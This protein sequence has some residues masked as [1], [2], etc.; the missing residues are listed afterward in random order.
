MKRDKKKG[1]L[2]MDNEFPV[3]TSVFLWLIIIVSSVMLLIQ[4]VGSMGVII[5]TPTTIYFTIEAIIILAV[6]LIYKRRTIYGLYIFYAML[7]MQIPLGMMLGSVNMGGILKAVIIKAL[8]MSL[9]VF[10]PSKGVS[11]Y[12]VMK[13]KRKKGEE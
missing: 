10:I 8:V 3:F 4:L 13:D 2:S 6:F 9:I 1:K 7:L 5:D 12:D 11:A